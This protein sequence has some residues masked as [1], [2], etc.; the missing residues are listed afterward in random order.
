MI[1]RKE[2][3]IMKKKLKKEVDKKRKGRSGIGRKRI[4]ETEV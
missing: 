4:E 3:K 1:R 2:N